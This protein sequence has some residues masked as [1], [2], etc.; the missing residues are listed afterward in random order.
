MIIEIPVATRLTIVSDVR[1]N[2]N[3]IRPESGSTDLLSF[4][5][6]VNSLQ[7]SRPVRRVI[8]RHTVELM[9]IEA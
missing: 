4:A 8:R 5:I 6:A 9:D 3:N 7:S 1:Q 2:I